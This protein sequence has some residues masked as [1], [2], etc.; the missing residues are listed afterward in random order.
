MENA[1]LISTIQSIFLQHGLTLPPESAI[2]P[3]GR[4]R[5]WETQGKH[6]GKKNVWLAVY[7]TS[8]LHFAGGDWS[9]PSSGFKY[10]GNEGES[11]PLS[12]EESERIEEQ[13]RQQ[14]NEAAEAREKSLAYLKTW[15][16]L[17]TYDSRN[18]SVPHPYLRKKK[19]SRGHIARWDSNGNYLVFPLLNRDGKVKNLQ[20]IDVDGNKRY[21]KELS[22]EGLF[23][24][25]WNNTSDTSTPLVVEGIATGLSVLEATDRLVIVALDCNS[26]TEAIKS[27]S[28]WLMNVV[29]KLK[30]KPESF[31][32]RFI[33]IADNDISRA[34]EEGARKASREL[35][36]S[37]TVIPNFGDTAITDC[38]D[39]A[40]VFGLE[41]LGQI[42]N[43]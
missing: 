2:I 33:I 7:S 20:K 24:P 22:R 23:I 16:S 39:F 4:I 14:I 27:A 29:W 38:N 32:E 11:F 21:L 12:K 6:N 43:F 18:F 42:L 5:K 36:C 31:Y 9:I 41:A 28:Y 8:P 40:S 17:P 34:G 37:F 15:P 25:L 35:G 3:D 26:Y 13:K 1:N 19:L 10:L 30:S